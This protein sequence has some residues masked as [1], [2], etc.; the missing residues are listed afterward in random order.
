MG[1]QQ[2]DPYHLA[3]GERGRARMELLNEIYNPG[4]FAFLLRNN[5]RPGARVLEIGCGPGVLTAWLAATVGPTGSVTAIDQSAEQ[6]RIAKRRVGNAP[7]VRFEEASTYQLA[8]LDGEFDVVFGRWVL[9]HA[10]DAEEST[11]SI[12][13]KAARDG[14]VVLEDCVTD[15]AFCHPRT[16]AFDRFI[17]GWLRVS[18]AS[19]IDPRVGDRLPSLLRGAGCTVTD[20]EVWQPL[21][22]TAREKQ[23]PSL[24]LE[25]TRD[26]HV[27][28]GALQ[29]NEVHST[30]AELAALGNDERTVMGFVRNV[31]VAGRARCAR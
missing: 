18:E 10:V 23:L 9:L 28:N 29:K 16:D 2:R 6:L 13:S 7:N 17:D 19:G 3:V 20:Y 11:R 26:A 8:D 22:R 30:V 25:E 1:R 4:T 15:S 14:V 27:R 21:L 12:V 24:S 5:L 31:R